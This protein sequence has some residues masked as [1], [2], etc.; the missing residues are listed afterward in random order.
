MDRMIKTVWMIC[1]ILLVLL[2]TF[3]SAYPQIYRWTDKK[4]TIHFTDSPSSLPEDYR[5]EK[6]RDLGKE[7]DKSLREI[8]A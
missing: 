6:K 4:G 7:V 1:T 8:R 5:E 3:P 2:F